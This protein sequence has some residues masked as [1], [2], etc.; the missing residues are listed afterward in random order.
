M[1]LYIMFSTLTDEG[2]KTIKTNPERIKGVN[3][4]VE[5]MG[6]RVIAQYATLGMYDFVNILEAPD[7]ETIAMISIELGARGT[8][9]FMTLAA[10]PLHEY[11]EKMEGEPGAI[12]RSILSALPAEYEEKMY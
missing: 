10:M 2:R 11:L 3:K 6:A 7:N 12:P 8:V 9:Q 1:P 4:E 5:G